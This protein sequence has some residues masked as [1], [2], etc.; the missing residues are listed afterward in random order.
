MDGVWVTVCAKR[1]VLIAIMVCGGCAEP[2]TSFDVEQNT[3]GNTVDNEREAPT[4]SDSETEWLPTSLTGIESV[5]R[6]SIDSAFVLRQPAESTIEVPQVDMSES[7]TESEVL[8]EG[9]REVD[10]CELS[11]RVQRLENASHAAAEAESFDGEAILTHEPLPDGTWRWSDYMPSHQSFNRESVLADLVMPNYSDDWEVFDRALDWSGATR[12]YEMP[13]G[14]FLLTESAAYAHWLEIVRKTLW[15]EV[16]Q[17]VG[18]R[19]VIGVRGSVPGSFL[20]HG[21]PKNQFNDTIVLLWRDEDG[22]PKVKEFPMTADPGTY[23]FPANESSA[24]YPNRHYAYINGWHRGY[25]ALSIVPSG[26]RVRDDGNKNGH[27]DDDRNG[28]LDGGIEDRFRGGSAHNIHMASPSRSI[29]NQII[30]NWSAGC[31]VIPGTN[32]WMEFIGHAW[33]NLN[34]QVDYF[35]L[36]ARDIAPHVWTSCGSETGTHRCP[37]A[38]RTFPIELEGSTQTSTEDIFDQYNCSPADESGPEYVYVLNLRTEGTLS[39]Q[40]ETD[41]AEA[42]PDI[43]LLS[44][45]DANA[46]LTRAHEGFEFDASPGRYLLVVDSWVDDAGQVRDGHYRLQVNFTP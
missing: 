17:T 31:Q 4:P 14:N 28:W 42:D 36:D 5:T 2:D 22:T 11:Y 9:W 8:P 1:A 32:N 23:P 46:C 19:T 44:G 30:H 39:V 20:W 16:E 6:E 21:N 43:H 12:C 34:D 13:H 26:Y 7:D 37:E 40:V 27:W 3:R 33:T 45:D 35:L 10:T 24:L 25:N 18:V 38:I 15:Y 29:E 41:D